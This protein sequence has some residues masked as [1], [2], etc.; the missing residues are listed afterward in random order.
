MIEGPYKLP[1]GWRWVRLGEVCETTSGGTPSRRRREYFSGNIPWVKSGELKDGII[2]GTE[3]T[4]TQLGLK[5]SNA[6]LFPSGTLLMAMYGATVGKLGILGCEAATNQAICAIVPDEKVLRKDFLF[7][8]LLFKR[9]AL[10]TRSFGGAQPNIS[11]TVIR[12][13]ELPLPPL[14]EQ[15]RIVA[16]LDQ[17]QQQVTALKHVQAETEAELQRLG[18]A[19]LDRAFKGEL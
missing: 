15:R 1:K 18:Q 5:H 9:E 16:Y 19:I 4:I 8:F 10:I 2:D 7:Y 11:Q 3:E 13:L 12:N 6:K 17:V 14:S